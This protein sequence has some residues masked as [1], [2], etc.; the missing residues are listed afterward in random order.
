MRRDYR[1]VKAIGSVIFQYLLG[2]SP[3]YNFLLGDVLVVQGR[4]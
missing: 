1:C 4:I 2:A 3:Y